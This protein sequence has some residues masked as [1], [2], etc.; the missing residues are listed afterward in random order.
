MPMKLN[1]RSKQPDLFRTIQILPQWE[2]MPESVRKE[3]L[4]LLRELL[5][6]AAAQQRLEQ[7]RRNH[8]EL[9]CRRYRAISIAGERASPVGRS[10]QVRWF[11]SV[12]RRVAQLGRCGGRTV[13]STVPDDAAAAEAAARALTALRGGAGSRPAPHK[14]PVSVR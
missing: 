4:P 14:R 7:L 13:V 5:F 1:P 3:L 10:A 8:N 11:L 12:T 6:S 9:D 2:K